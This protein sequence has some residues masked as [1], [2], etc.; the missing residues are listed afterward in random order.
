MMNL[1]NIKHA[2]VKDPRQMVCSRNCSSRC[3]KGSDI[4]CLLRDII[5]YY[6][7]DGCG[8]RVAYPSEPDFTVL[9]K[10]KPSTEGRNNI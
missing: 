5:R 9:V 8:G 4:G 2:R 1:K 7:E 3:K 10:N 6:G